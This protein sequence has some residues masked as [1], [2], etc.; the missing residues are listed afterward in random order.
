MRAARLDVEW[1][2]AR[3]EPDALHLHRFGQLLGQSQVEPAQRQRLAIH[4]VDLRPE[5][6]EDAREF[7]RNIAS[8]H[9]RDPL[10]QRG[11]SEC[12]VRH[13]AEFLPGD[14]RPHRMA[15]GRD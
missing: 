9:N 5:R 12:I 7:D 11:Q 13:D 14:A 4:E 6:R 2:A 15:A 8:A 1:R 3:V 10:R